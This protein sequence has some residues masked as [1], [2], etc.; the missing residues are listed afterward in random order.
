LEEQFFNFLWVDPLTHCNL[1]SG[2]GV[3]QAP[4]S[5]CPDLLV[6]LVI[7]LEETFLKH[8]SLHIFGHNPPTFIH[9]NND[10]H[11]VSPLTR[12]HPCPGM[13]SCL[14]SFYGLTDPLSS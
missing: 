12:V 6:C 10:L 2:I 14:L 1:R 3:N 5:P 9:R 13:S 4:I 8:V 7:R 11:R